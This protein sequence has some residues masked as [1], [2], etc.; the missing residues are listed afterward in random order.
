MTS[1]VT[2]IPPGGRFSF[3][4]IEI[5]RGETDLVISN[6]HIART[7][8]LSL[9]VP[10]TTSLKDRRSGREHADERGDVDFSFMGYNMPGAVKRRTD[11]VLQDLEVETRA[12][13]LFDGEHVVIRLRILD[14]VQELLLIREYFIYPELPVLA[15]RCG[16]RAAVSP[17][18]AW[19]P[20]GAAFNKQADPAF[21]ESRMESLRLQKGFDV[22]RVVEFFGRTDFSNELLREECFTGPAFSANGNL[23]FAEQAGAGGVF[24][25]QEAPPSNERRDLDACD[26]RFSDQT[27]S[28]CCWGIAPHEVSPD[29]ILYGYRNVIGVY[30]EGGI[31]SRRLLKDYLRTRFPQNPKKDF[32]V[33]VNPWGSGSFQKD[34][35]EQYLIDE[36]KASAELGATHYQIDDGWQRGKSLSALTLDNQA[37]GEEFWKISD[38]RLPRGFE[39]LH[40]AAK[41]NQVELA[42]WLAPSFNREFRDWEDFVELMGGFHRRFG[43]RMFKIDGVRIRT[44]EAEDNLEKMVRTLRSES[45]GDILFNFDT[46]DGERSGYFLFLEYGNIFLE[47]RYAC[48]DWGQVYHPEQA[49]RNFWTLAGYVRPQTLQ[50]EVT[51]YLNINREYYDQQGISHPDLYSPQYWAAVT[52]FANPLIWLAPSKLAPSIKAAYRD[53]LRLHLQHREGIFSGE[54]FP[55][56]SKPNGCSLTGFQ[57]HRFEDHSGFLVVYREFGAP[58]TG[59]VKMHFVNLLHMKFT[60]LSDGSGI[61]EKPVGQ[62]HFDVRLESPGSFRLYKYEVHGE[63]GMMLPQASKAQR[64]D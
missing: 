56:G 9:A 52:L 55:V 41:A 54:I 21:L 46:T 5:V 8:D 49:L 51:D 42:L 53:V 60:S 23:A 18:M 20:R 22:F 61:I 2:S 44:K 43:I 12:P 17:K 4:D 38:S 7:F 59:S 32:S 27:L 47:N 63:M 58:E 33:M 45:D 29:Q 6:S 30:A 34:L 36:I 1:A 39:K 62:D 25:L 40:Q 19:A 57:S 24:I 64:C 26:F 16:I 10:R 48:H 28:S 11:F 35:S 14:S 50:I 15:A 13:S 3:K 31:A 37:A